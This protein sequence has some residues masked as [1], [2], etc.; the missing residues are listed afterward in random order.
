MLRDDD[1][2]DEIDTFLVRQDA[3]KLVEA[4]DKVRDGHPVRV[5]IAEE[6]PAEYRVG[7]LDGQ[8]FGRHNDD[9]GDV[10]ETR[11]PKLSLAPD[12]LNCGGNIDAVAVAAGKE[13]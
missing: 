2:I 11:H 6:C 3:E 5:L 4:W 10:G 7:A 13:L 12:L 1:A 9:A 8:T